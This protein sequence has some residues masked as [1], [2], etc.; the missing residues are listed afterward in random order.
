VVD[1]ASDEERERRG[2]PLLEQ[3]RG[4]SRRV[5]LSPE[6]RHP[7]IILG[8]HRRRRLSP[9]AREDEVK[10]G[11]NI[12]LVAQLLVVRRSDD[13]R[14]LRLE[15][16]RPLVERGRAGRRG[17]RVGRDERGSP[18]GEEGLGRLGD[19]G[20]GTLGDVLDSKGETGVHG[21]EEGGDVDT[22][23][24]GEG[25]VDGLD[26]KSLSGKGELVLDLDHGVAGSRGE[27][28]KIEWNRFERVG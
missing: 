14:H 20:R 9:S 24:I 18:F 15:G 7:E 13:A 12:D 11:P 25:G 1:L 2:E 3:H 27:L 8:S 10:V 26:V 22:G 17:E 23:A 4:L 21:S 16:R 5:N 19:F 6:R 28:L